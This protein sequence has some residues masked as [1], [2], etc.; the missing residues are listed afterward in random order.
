MDTSTA[1]LHR[2]LCLLLNF[3]PHGNPM[4]QPSHKSA[5]QPTFNAEFNLIEGGH[6]NYTSHIENCVAV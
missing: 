3:I 2:I 1:G 4:T 5:S 6:G